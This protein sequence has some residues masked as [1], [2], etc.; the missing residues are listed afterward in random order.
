MVNNI[1]FESAVTRAIKKSWFDEDFKSA[2]I[3]NPKKMLFEEFGDTIDDEVSI[4]V[5]DAPDFRKE[6]FVIN[7]SKNSLLIKIPPKST[8]VNAELT[9][10]QLEAAA[11]GNLLL[12]NLVDK[13]EKITSGYSPPPNA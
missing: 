9:D 6:D 1:E 4:A 7:R 13:I 2:L 8:I 12:A 11:G 5:V 3:V 10:D